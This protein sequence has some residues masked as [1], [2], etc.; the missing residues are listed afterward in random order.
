[1]PGTEAYDL[2]GALR[3]RKPDSI[4][5]WVSHIGLLMTQGMLEA[6]LDVGENALAAHP[7]DPA[8]LFQIANINEMAGRPG[9]AEAI[10][11]EL[12]QRPGL[13]V[14]ALNNLALLLAKDSARLG[15]ALDYAQQAYEL[16]PQWST[17]ED[18]LGWVLHL[19]GRSDEA[20]ARLRSALQKASGDSEILCH[21]AIAA[22]DAGEPDASDLIQECLA[23]GPPQQLDAAVR[24][25]ASR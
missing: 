5:M 7:E 19:N 4:E 25:L 10:Y 24:S 20:L 3:A 18:T 1:M 15:E 17:I 6:A 21:F 22:S 23:A 13:G 2:R 14:A 9:R 11:S 8:L 16:S 12:A